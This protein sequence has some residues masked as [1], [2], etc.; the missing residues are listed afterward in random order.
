MPRPKQRGDRARQTE[1]ELVSQR[2]GEKDRMR[3]G[4]RART[5]RYGVGES[6]AKEERTRDKSG[7]NKKRQVS[8]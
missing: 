6:M 4:E 8:R 7:R 1:A 3:K 5:D 2:E